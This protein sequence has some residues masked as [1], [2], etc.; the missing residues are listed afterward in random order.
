MNKRSNFSCCVGLMCFLSFKSILSAESLRV[1]ASFSVLGDLVTVVGGNHVQVSTLVGPGGDAHMYQP[2]PNDA[3]AVA[4]AQLVVM[5]G[6]HFEGWLDRLLQASGFSGQIVVLSAGATLRTMGSSTDA[7]D[8]H[9]WQNLQNGV[10]YVRNLSTALQKVDPVH[11]T[12]YQ[13]RSEEYL[14]KILSLDQ[15]IRKQL[16]VLPSTRRRLITSHEAFGYF[17]DAYGLTILAPAGFNNDAEASAFRVG[18]LI[19]QIRAERI[20]AVFVENVT[21][22]RLMHQISRESGARIGGVLYSDALSASQGPAAT[23][24]DMFRSNTKTLLEALVPSEELEKH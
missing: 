3:R 1:V 9:A 13:K 16:A 18:T 8:P 5:N 10:I 20:H 7:I 12:D 14:A 24:L 17:A 11:A 23:Y 21:D 22:P 15:N 2:T 19:R 6:L 4:K